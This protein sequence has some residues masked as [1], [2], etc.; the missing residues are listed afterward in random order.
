MAVIEL[1][2]KTYKEI[3]EEYFRDRST[4]IF[5]NSCMDH[6]HVIIQ[7]IFTYATDY[8]YVFSHKLDKELWNESD[9][10][11]AVRN[12]ASRGVKIEFAIQE[13]T[14]D[15]NEL[16]DVLDEYGIQ[17]RTDVNKE[18]KENFIVADN[19]MLRYEDCY[20]QVE[21]MASANREDL[22]LILKNYFEVTVLGIS[23]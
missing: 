9:I 13:H 12:A 23:A 4:E 15:A 6:A 14:V 8:V 20:A 10:I 17:L 3:V 1:K 5:P 16:S 22:S 7:Q 18:D 2:N 19:R 21:A 11:C